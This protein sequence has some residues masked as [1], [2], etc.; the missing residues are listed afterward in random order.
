[1]VEEVAQ[2]PS[3]TLRHLSKTCLRITHLPKGIVD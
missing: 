2:Q 1:V 3:R